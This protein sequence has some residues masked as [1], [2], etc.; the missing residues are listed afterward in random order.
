MKF[1]CNRKM[2]MEYLKVSKKMI[3]NKASFAPVKAITLNVE[4]DNVILKCI[5]NDAG[6]HMMD[7]TLQCEVI[8]EG[9]CLID[10]KTLENTLKN[11]NDDFIEVERIENILYINSGSF[12]SKNMLLNDDVDLDIVNKNNYEKVSTID[13]SELKKMIKLTLPAISNDV[14]RPILNCF[15]MEVLKDNYISLTSIDGYRLATDKTHS[16]NDMEKDF[17]IPSKMLNILSAMKFKN[18]IEIFSNDKHIKFTINNI[19]LYIEVVRGEFIEYKKLISKD[20]NTRVT[21]NDTKK[22]HDILK[23]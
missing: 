22:L 16:K 21:I 15:Y 6:S 3:N 18:D 5:N 20:H 11:C 10:F 17:I 7:I 23:A 12:K 8:K 13:F 14:T 1:I 2:F 9:S 4:K 19:N